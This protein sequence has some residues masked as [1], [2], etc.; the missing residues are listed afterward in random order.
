MRSLAMFLTLA[1]LAAA[2]A[3]AQ[4]SQPLVSENTTQ[5]SEH[6]WAIMGF[7]NIAIVVGGRA[8]LVVDTGLG[9]KNGATAARVA[10]RLAPPR[11]TMRSSSSP[12]R[13]SIRSTPAASR[14]FLQEPS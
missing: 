11:P 1:A 6:V 10:A 14:A 12:P 8:T 13:T 4:T 7:P 3:F 2:S 5:I 9:P